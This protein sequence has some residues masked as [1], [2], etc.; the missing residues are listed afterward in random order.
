MT[1]WTPHNYTDIRGDLRAN[2]LLAKRTW[3]GVGGPADLYFEPADEADL[4]QFLKQ[5]PADMPITIIGAGSNMLV[6]DG[7]L[8]GCVIRLAGAL[9]DITEDD[10]IITA[11]AG[12]SDA[13]L[14][15][16]A[17]RHNRA[18]LGF[19]VSIPGT[20]GGGLR[21]NAGCYGVEFKDVVISA[22]LMDRQ[23]NITEMTPDEMGM[24][25]RHSD[26]PDDTIFLSTQFATQ[27]GDSAI[28]K[29]EMKDMLAM[30]AQT[31]PQGV[32]TGGSTFANPDGHKAWQV[33]DE[34]GCR[35]L[36]IGHARMSDKHCN[37]MINEGGAT[38][39]DLERL[40]ETVRARVKQTKEIELRWEI[41]RLGRPDVAEPADG[42]LEEG[43]SHG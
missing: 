18:G 4:A 30:R 10:D 26:V 8:E 29:A 24:A 38:A 39:S 1:S 20:I 22:R 17:A 3:L 7:G 16:F 6:R 23:G 11:G 12:A 34:A 13:D 14:A 36:A 42:H 9:A 32:R 43:V 28:L 37:F 33:I 41:K 2:E 40:G 27:A 31:Q 15:R 5:S 21:M 19:L 25:Y 35:G